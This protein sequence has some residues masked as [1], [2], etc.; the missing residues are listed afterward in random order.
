MELIDEYDKNGNYK[1]V[2]DKDV[3]HRDGLWHKAVHVWIVNDDD[4][5]MLQYRCSKKKFFPNVWDTSFAG[6]IDAGETS[7][8]AVIREGKEELGINVNTSKLTHLFTMKETLVYKDI[9]SNEFVDVFL[10]RDNIKLDTLVLQDIEV[11]ATKYMKIDRFFEAIKDPEE[12]IM[13]HQE[14]YKQLKKILKRKIDK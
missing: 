8:D 9:K 3:A 2:I 4:E 6:H 11:G 7:L 14:E 12:G 1:G 10:L 5:I 13:D